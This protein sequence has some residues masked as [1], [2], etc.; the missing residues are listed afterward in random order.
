MSMVGGVHQLVS[1]AIVLNSEQ[2]TILETTHV[3]H[4]RDPDRKVL[5]FRRYKD[6][7]VKVKLWQNEQIFQ[8]SF[9]PTSARP[10]SSPRRPAREAAPLART[11]AAT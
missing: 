8:A 9:T 3:G 7:D 1:T 4:F 5:T 6:G 10:T 11:S 2:V